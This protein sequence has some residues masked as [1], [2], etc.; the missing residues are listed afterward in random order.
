MSLSNIAETPILPPA[1]AWAESPKTPLASKGLRERVSGLTQAIFYAIKQP[2]ILGI[3][4]GTII[5]EPIIRVLNVQ[6]LPTKCMIAFASAFFSTLLITLV[7]KKNATPPVDATET[8]RESKKSEETHQEQA[9]KK[10]ELEEA[11]LK[12]TTAKLEQDLTTIQATIDAIQLLFDGLDE[13]TRTQLTSSYDALKQKLREI[14]L[15]VQDSLCT[16]ASLTQL[17]KQAKRIQLLLKSVE[18]FHER[19]KKYSKEQQQVGS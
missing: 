10:L 2:I 1:A 11:E 16:G 15:E 17:S 14:T 13:E 8:P 5:G 3:I 18:H 6:S 4:S 9:A 19:M 7:K 12:N